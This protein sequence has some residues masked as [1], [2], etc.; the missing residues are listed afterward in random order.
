MSKRQERKARKISARITKDIRFDLRSPCDD[1]PFRTDAPMHE[2]IMSELPQKILL[3]ESGNLAH[4]CHK[5]DPRADCAPE[6][7]APPGSPIQHCAGA[8]IMALKIDK[9]Q[10][11]MTRGLLAGKF[12]HE[13]LNINAPVFSSPMAMLAHYIPGM[14]EKH[15]HHP[16]SK[17]LMKF[18]AQLLDAL[19][20]QQP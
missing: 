19:A 4:T 17:E 14:V 1:C 10:H 15:P 9:W 18:H 12:D 6:R 7:R 16:E 13:R 5:T 11:I 8:I 20:R 3:L 2:G